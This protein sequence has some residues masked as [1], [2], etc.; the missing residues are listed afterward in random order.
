VL[1]VFIIDSYTI[2]INVTIT[3]VAIIIRLIAYSVDASEPWDECSYFCGACLELG[4]AAD[5]ATCD[6]L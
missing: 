2:G 4:G 6:V 3:D 1:F 5:V